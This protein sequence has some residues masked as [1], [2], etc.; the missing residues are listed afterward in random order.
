MSENDERYTRITLRIPKELHAKLQ[1][2]ADQTSHSMNAEIVQRLEST[3][4]MSATAM[5]DGR[6]VSISINP[7]EYVATVVDSAAIQLDYI[8]FTNMLLQEKSVINDTKLLELIKDKVRKFASSTQPASEKLEKLS[9]D[10][11]SIASSMLDADR[12]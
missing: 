1:D 9:S 10:L 4:R 5:V 8:E 3:F 2:A 11:R 7:M 6:V 12:P